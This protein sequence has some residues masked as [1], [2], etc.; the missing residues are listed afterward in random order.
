MKAVAVA[1][2]CA[3]VLAPCSAVNPVTRVV[4]LLKALS[5]QVEKEGKIEEGM[6]EDYVCWGKSVINQKTASNA[7]ATSRI[8]ELEAYI[9]DLDSGRVELTSERSD[10]E[11]EI[12]GLMSDMETSTANRKKREC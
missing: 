5:A 7:A 6:Y 1:L 3:L 9:A 4:D 10:L 12:A 11:K 8:D 2:V